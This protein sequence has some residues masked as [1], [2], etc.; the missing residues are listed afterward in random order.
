MLGGDICLLF[1]DSSC[2]DGRRFFSDVFF[3]SVI[4]RFIWCS[5]FSFM[6]CS[7][8]RCVWCIRFISFSREVIFVFVGSIVDWLFVRVGWVNIGV[9]GFFVVEG[10]VV[11]FEF[12]KEG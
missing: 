8:F 11:V 4:F 5:I 9:G 2:V 7:I 6:W 1:V 3:W 12:F 10:V